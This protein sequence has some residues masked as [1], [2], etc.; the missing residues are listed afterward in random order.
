MR[1]LKKIV[2]GTTGSEIAEAA[3]VLPI[4]FMLLLGIYWFGR[5]FNVYATINHAAREGARA[6]TAST[7]ATCGTPNSP[8]TADGVAAQVKQSLEASHLVPAQVAPPA[9]LPVRTACGTNAPV[10]C[11]A[12]AGG[13]PQV[14]V[15]FNVNL[16]PSASLSP[17]SGT[18]ACGVAVEFQYPYQF[19]FPF[20]SLNMQTI[21]LSAGV[22]MAGEY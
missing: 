18:P 3:L 12:V 21:T 16:Q 10:A 5:A 4:L 6:G 14:C 15:R 22:Q 9:S 11:S 7:C 19:S 20:T 2:T 1:R 13:N 17:G 8:L